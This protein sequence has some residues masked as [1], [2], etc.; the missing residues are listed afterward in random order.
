MRELM[1]SRA[2]Q[3][4]ALILYVLSLAGVI[5][6]YF[7]VSAMEI[8]YSV[9]LQGSPELVRG[10]PNAVRG[11]L[12]NA[13]NGRILGRVAGVSLGLER[14]GVFTELATPSPGPG[15]VMH[16]QLIPPTS[17]AVGE[18]DLVLRATIS[19]SEPVF[20]SR[21]PVEVIAPPKPAR[22][23][24]PAHVERM[25]EVERERTRLG[26][27]DGDGPVRIDVIP[28]RPVLARGL[29][30]EVFLRATDRVTGEPL[31]CEIVFDE[32]KGLLEQGEP[33]R[34]VRTDATGLARVR[35]APTTTHHWELSTRCGEPLDEPPPAEEGGSSDDVAEEV[36][37][38]RPRSEA[39]VQ[40]GTAPSQLT[41]KMREPMAM[42]GAGVD[43]L[44][45]SLFRE[46]GLY[47]DLYRDGRWVWAGS[48]GLRDNAGGVRLDVPEGLGEGGYSLYR[49]Q[50]SNDIYFQGN[51]W[52]VR[53]LM[54]GSSVTDASIDAAIERVVARHLEQPG[55]DEERA[56]YLRFLE[57]E[58]ARWRALPSRARLRMLAALLRDVPTH[59]EFPPAVMNSLDRDQRELDAWKQGV[60]DQL[61][62]IAALVALVGVLVLTLAVLAG[63]QQALRRQ[64]LYHQVE[65]ELAEQ[66]LPDLDEHIDAAAVLR[67]GKIARA[68]AVVQG[69]VVFGTLIIFIV[70]VLLMM[71]YL[72]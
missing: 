17:L 50:I 35:F 15:G 12:M 48:F 19:M 40:L 67:D 66:D 30:G 69:G 60:R 70:G 36:E 24:W 68:M 9:Y 61:M 37:D 38:P 63:V 23:E 64:E 1:K 5:F 46:G 72:M 56:A 11:M 43:G 28:E 51:A 7:V 47:A 32:V 8:P 6:V 4:G 65:L 41:L 62:I 33:P 53:H 34:R 13:Q 58:P 54:S 57:R 26:L 45:R 2:V 22:G 14:D 27:L 31:A 16:A 52:D 42:P 55:L 21:A 49:V 71:R 3:R 29:P 44:V 10:E 39:R 25:P 59:F 18:Y 20:E